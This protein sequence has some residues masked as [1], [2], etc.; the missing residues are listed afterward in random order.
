MTSSCQVSEILLS[1]SEIGKAEDVFLFICFVCV[2]GVWLYLVISEVTPW[3]YTQAI[4]L[5]VTGN[6]IGSQEP[7]LGWHMQGK[8]LTCSTI[9]WAPRD[10]LKRILGLVNTLLGKTDQSS[11]CIISKPSSLLPPCPV[12]LMFCFRNN[13]HIFYQFFYD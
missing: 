6:S 12:S 8:H 4:L 9:A 13:R 2:W 3:L 10:H 11:N 7:N 5:V 1:A